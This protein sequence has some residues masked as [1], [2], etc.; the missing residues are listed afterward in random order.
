LTG[1]FSRIL[2]A[3]AYEGGKVLNPVYL[4][5]SEQLGAE[6]GNIEPAVGS[7]SKATIVEV[8]CIN[9][10]VRLKQM[11][12][13]N[14]KGRPKAAPRPISEEI[15]GINLYINYILSASVST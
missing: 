1:T 15:E 10:G 3:I 12:P 14:S 13:R 11:S 8:E 2:R 7:V 6:L 4:V 5:F 9:V